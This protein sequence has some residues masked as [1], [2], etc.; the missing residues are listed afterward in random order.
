MPPVLTTKLGENGF[1]THFAVD[2][3]PDC[4]TQG[5]TAD[6]TCVATFTPGERAIAC[7]CCRAVTLASR[8]RRLQQQQRKRYAL[9]V[10]SED[11][12]DYSRGKNGWGVIR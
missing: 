7:S 9:C 10:E 2:R 1:S 5:E 6:E 3:N 12:P 11:G 4:T 8:R